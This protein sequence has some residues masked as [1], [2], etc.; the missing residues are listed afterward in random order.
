MKGDCPQEHLTEMY[1]R[2]F[3]LSDGLLAGYSNHDSS[4]LEDRGSLIVPFLEPTCTEPTWAY[5]LAEKHRDFTT[6]VELCERDGEM[7]KLEEF[8]RNF[9][10][11][12]VQAKFQ[13]YMREGKRYK[14]LDQAD[15]QQTA[16]GNFLTS[17]NSLEWLQHIHLSNFGKAHQALK[18]LAFAQIEP[19]SVSRKRSL[20]SLSKLSLLASDND[21][22]EALDELDD[23]LTI[24]NYQSMIPVEALRNVGHHE[25]PDLVVPLPRADIIDL[26][27]GNNPRI[28][29][30]TINNSENF[31][32]AL[33][34]LCSNLMMEEHEFEEHRLVVLA[35]CI[36]HDT[37]RWLALPDDEPMESI[38]ETILFKTIAQAQAESID[39]SGIN[40][41][42]LCEIANE[43]LLK[44][45]EPQLQSK[46]FRKHI[47]QAIQIGVQI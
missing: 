39:M 12:F 9:G 3:E 38:A 15:G 47:Q 4:F 43:A 14:L 2:L 45:G 17:H 46:K 22:D 18:N 1:R 16:L 23:E 19:N 24:L 29:S 32:V 10:Q 35:H 26:L 40:V 25:E 8:S 27:I 42:S 36:V 20:L 44:R 31:V 11:E 21:D 5:E 28:S 33:K 13:W 34:M 30:K 7:G 37:D 41:T 6:L